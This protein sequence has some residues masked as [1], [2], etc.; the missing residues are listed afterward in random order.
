MIEQWAEILQLKDEERMELQ[1]AQRLWRRRF[2][3]PGNKENH[4][5]TALQ[6]F[7]PRL[8][9]NRETC[10][11]ISANLWK[12]HKYLLQASP[13]NK[14]KGSKQMFSLFAF[15]PHLA[16]HGHKQTK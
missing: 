5:Q 9:T 16:T 13:G 6:V 3:F 12:L 4:L 1:F 10:Q 8:A 15:W 2:R 11:H 7:R 14:Q